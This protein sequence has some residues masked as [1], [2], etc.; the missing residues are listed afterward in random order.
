MILF[1]EMSEDELLEELQRAI[2][3]APMRL[4]V[5][6][7]DGAAGHANAAA[8]IRLHEQEG[9]FLLELI[10]DAKPT[11]MRAALGSHGAAA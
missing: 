1:V 11:L 9:R 4:E 10:N 2:P 6:S 8:N 5:V 7:R 3:F